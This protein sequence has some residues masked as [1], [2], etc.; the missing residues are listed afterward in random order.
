M[1]SL[2]IAVATL[3]LALLSACAGEPDTVEVGGNAEREFMPDHFRIGLLLEERGEDSTTLAGPLERRL[4]TVLA[5]ARDHGLEDE[6]VQAWEVQLR[7]ETHWDRER[8]R[9]VPGDMRLSRQLRLSVDAERD[10]GELL[11]ELLA[12]GA[13]Q[14]QHIQP[15]LSDPDGARKELLGDAIADARRRAEGMANGDDRHVGRLIRAS[16]Q[17]GQHQP[18]LAAQRMEADS[19]AIE[20]QPGPITVSAQVQA[21]FELD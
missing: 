3:S 8:Q 11:G 4:N 13:A 15:G 10:M 6:D 16:E 1:K 19:A 18:F 7:Q 14:I 5:I 12:S 21:V 20:F 17:G 2:Q 9:Q